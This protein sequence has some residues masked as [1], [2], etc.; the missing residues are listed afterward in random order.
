LKEHRQALVDHF[1]KRLAAGGFEGLT[2]AEFQIIR[3]HNIE[4]A[5]QT[6]AQHREE[7]NGTLVSHEAGT[8][9]PMRSSRLQSMISTSMLPGVST[10]FPHVKEATSM[11]DVELRAD[12]LVRSG[13]Q[14][15]TKRGT[16]E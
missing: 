16:N 6:A 11:V 8:R 12:E 1:R 5:V 15:A 14:L 10:I 7:F 9:L 3:L 13:T 2:T 4:S